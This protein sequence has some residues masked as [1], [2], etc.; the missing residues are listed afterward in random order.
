MFC[1]QDMV[2]NSSDE[3]TSLNFDHKLVPGVGISR[4]VDLGQDFGAR[5][6]GNAGHLLNPNRFFRNQYSP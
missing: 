1:F 6:L 5:L 2:I 4:D 3:L